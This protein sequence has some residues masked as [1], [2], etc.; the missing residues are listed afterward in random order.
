VEG[1]KHLRIHDKVKRIPI[2]QLKPYHNNPKEHPEEQIEKIKK[3]IKEYGFTVPLIVAGNNEVIAGHGRLK[4]AKELSMDRLPC[5]KREDLT[6]E[7]ARGLRIADNKITE[8]EW[9]EEQLAAEFESLDEDDF[10]G[11][12]EIEIDDIWEDL[13]PETEV[14]SEKYTDKIES[15]TYEPTREEQPPI[16]ELI[17]TD[18]F[19]KLL[20]KIKKAD[21]PKYKKDFL[22]LAA[23]RHIVFDYE[24]IAEYYAHADKKVQEL[25]EDLALVIIDMDKAIEEGFTKFSK[26]IL[27]D[28]K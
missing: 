3:S 1:V 6:E 2:N 20:N 22:K 14:D 9:N 27:K 5:I 8:S 16:N 19:E 26:D 11:F 23:H 28:E 21:I 10:T 15:P 24:N 17:D 12:D 18:K 4:A 7:Q 13:E 25:M